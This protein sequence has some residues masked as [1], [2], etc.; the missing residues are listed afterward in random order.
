MGNEAVTANS[1]ARSCSQGGW[2]QAGAA[3]RR[4]VDRNSVGDSSSRSPYVNETLARGL[5][6]QA[7]RAL[8]DAPNAAINAVFAK[9]RL[10]RTSF[11]RRPEII[12]MLDSAHRLL[13][14]HALENGIRR[15]SEAL[16][17]F[18]PRVIG[19]ECL[20]ARL[21][22]AFERAGRS[23][24]PMFRVQIKSIVLLSKHAI[25]RMFER[26]NVLA[27]EDV[28]RSLG[29]FMAM[30]PLATAAKQARLSHAFMPANSGMFVLAF[31]HEAEHPVATTYI[32]EPGVEKDRLLA[33]IRC[34]LPDQQPASEDQNSNASNSL[35]ALFQSE[36]YSPWRGKS[37]PRFKLEA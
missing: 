32:S 19:D 3:V 21:D 20:I 36:R 37:A 4:S 5:R 1:I 13:A 9:F 17:A 35:Q 6:R 16:T 11:L 7:F 18:L 31:D 23:N 27:W 8:S 2:L 26:L 15:R 24:R 12:R 33:P 34:C 29:A 10:R 28:L 22:I 30:Q 14:P 25:E